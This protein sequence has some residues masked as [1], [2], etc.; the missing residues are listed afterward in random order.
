MN[1]IDRRRSQG[2]TL[3]KI[4]EGTDTH[5]SIDSR[6]VP[7]HEATDMPTL[8]ECRTRAAQGHD[9]EMGEKAHHAHHYRTKHEREQFEDR[10]RKGLVTQK[11]IETLHDRLTL[12]RDDRNVLGGMDPVDID[13]DVTGMFSAKK[14]RNYMTKWKILDVEDVE[15][16]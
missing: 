7:G 11:D 9:A 5:N 14:K 15:L 12:E 1:T 6:D 3:P 8:D 10:V 2:F 4:N 13:I 16:I